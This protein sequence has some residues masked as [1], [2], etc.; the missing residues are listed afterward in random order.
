MKL[1]YYYKEVKNFFI[2]YGHKKSKTVKIIVS[3][4]TTGP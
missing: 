1:R 4:L 3:N 2:D